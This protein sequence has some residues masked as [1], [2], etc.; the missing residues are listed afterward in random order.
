MLIDLPTC[1]LV[2]QSS[3]KDDHTR[4]SKAGCSC[5]TIKWSTEHE[6]PFQKYF[7]HVPSQAQKLS[8]R[9]GQQQLLSS[10]Q[11]TGWQSAPLGSQ[12]RRACFGMAAGI[13]AAH[14]AEVQCTWGIQ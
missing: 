2:S 1:E 8:A 13:S 14:A 9:C 10:S 5:A 6:D 11:T 4:Q 12:A 7:N 3:F